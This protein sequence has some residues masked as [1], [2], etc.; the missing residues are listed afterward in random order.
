MRL[1]VQLG[2]EGEEKP[3]DLALTIKAGSPSHKLSHKEGACVVD[4]LAPGSVISFDDESV[5]VKSK[6]KKKKSAKG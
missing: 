5:E 4:G 1:H 6:S 2:L 3:G